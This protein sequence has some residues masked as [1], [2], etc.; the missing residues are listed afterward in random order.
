MNIAATASVV[1]PLA[2]ALWVFVQYW[3]A[4]IKEHGL[5]GF[6]KEELFPAGVPWPIYIILTPVQLLELVLI[7]PNL[8][9]GATVRQHG[10]RSSAGRH[11]L[12][13]HPSSI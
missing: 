13:V 6:L 10:R 7:R 9:D 5:G 11:L 12:C 1:M 2:F 3:R 8:A 4:G